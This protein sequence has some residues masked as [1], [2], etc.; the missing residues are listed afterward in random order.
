MLMSGE[1]LSISLAFPFLTPN[2]V[3][4]AK[5]YYFRI[6]LVVF[7]KKISVCNLVMYLKTIGNS[8]YDNISTILVLKF[9]F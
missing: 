9:F 3:T 8:F 1:T 5:D 2:Q 7:E 6:V 4:Q